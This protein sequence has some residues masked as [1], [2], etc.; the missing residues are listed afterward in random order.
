MAVRGRI[1]DRSNGD[2]NLYSMVKMV[3]DGVQKYIGIHI[4]VGRHFLP[5]PGNKETINH[6][7]GN[8]R[9]NPWWN[10]EWNTIPENNQH[11]RQTGL[12]DTKGE[13]H[14]M[15]FLNNEQVLEIAKSADSSKNLSKI[16]SVTAHVIN[17]I[18]R[19]VTWSHLTGIVYEKHH[20]K[21]LPDEAIEVYLSTAT[22]HEIAQKYKITQQ[23]V[24]YIK[25]GKSHSKITQN[26][27]VSQFRSPSLSSA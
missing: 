10:L 7:D 11:A 4:L 25:A 3:K 24:K 18:R 15:T 14:P 17:L 9:N 1:H 5:N 27:V 21:L 16:Y 13:N 23:A 12:N 6:K 19:G 20:R 2:P 22:N 8:K 26:L